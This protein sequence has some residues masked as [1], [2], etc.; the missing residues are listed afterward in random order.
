MY[1]KILK[2]KA[3]KKKSAPKQHPRI[4]EKHNQ[5]KEEGFEDF[6]GFK[7]LKPTNNRRFV[8]IKDG[9]IHMMQYN[10][11]TK[12]TWFCALDM[13]SEGSAYFKEDKVVLNDENDVIG[14][15][16]DIEKTL[17]NEFY[18]S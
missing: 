10:E 2:L 5:A 16:M 4:D 13:V 1:R 6:P 14:Y 12:Q 8:Y 17:G 7:E 9:N 11:V 3:G 18:E 15:I